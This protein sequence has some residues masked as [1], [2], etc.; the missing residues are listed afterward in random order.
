[1]ILIILFLSFKIFAQN[2]V[3]DDYNYPLSVLTDNNK[4]IE[5]KKGYKILPGTIIKTEGEHYGIIKYTNLCEIYIKPKT[6]LKFNK[7]D[8]TNKIIQIY[9]NGSIYFKNFQTE[10]NQKFDIF[11]STR[12]VNFKVKL[13]SFLMNDLN[14]K[15]NISVFNDN[16]I[17]E[18]NNHIYFFDPVIK[19]ISLDNK[20]VLQ[21][22]DAP[23]DLNSGYG[24]QFFQGGDEIGIS[25]APLKPDLEFP[26]NKSIITKGVNLVWKKKELKGIKKPEFDEKKYKIK[27]LDS[28]ENFYRIEIAK[29]EKFLN[30][31]KIVETSKNFLNIDDLEDGKY[32][33]RV[34]NIDKNNNIESLPSEVNSFTLQKPKEILVIKK[35]EDKANI[36]KIVEED[37]GKQGIPKE[38]KVAAGIWG[39]MLFFT[40]LILVII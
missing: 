20:L 11:I 35:K 4:N 2:F 7:I 1:M 9:V 10:T 40:F 6:I 13:A 8:L 26:E 31:V 30:F 33:W 32:F 34:I 16:L 28:D 22:Y 15:L 14:N 3:V 29:D 19:R 5:V 23:K 36:E 38:N 12:F 21:I 25:F 39:S 24:I 37:Y 18:F 27:W 17:A